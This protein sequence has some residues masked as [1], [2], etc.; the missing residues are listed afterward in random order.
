MIFKRSTSVSIHF[1]SFQI[2]NCN[3]ITLH[4][5]FPVPAMLT[6]I[7]TARPHQGL[8]ES[9]PSSLRA[10]LA[11]RKGQQSPAQQSGQSRTVAMPLR[12]SLLK[13]WGMPPRGGCHLWG[14][15]MPQ[16]IFLFFSATKESTQMTFKIETMVF[17]QP[18]K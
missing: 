7:S 14:T 16:S 4:P 1:S 2:L 9:Q 18:D 17:H 3:I 5:A 13:C 12:Q 15:H 10:S 8:P 11:P 6:T